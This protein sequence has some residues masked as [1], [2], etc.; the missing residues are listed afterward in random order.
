[1][2]LEGEMEFEVKFKISKERISDLLDTAF[3]GGSNYWYVIRE[4][5]YPAG[6]T[7]HD[8]KFPYLE[9]P[10]TEGGSLI[11][12]S[13]DDPDKKYSSKVL[14]LE[15]IKKGLEIMAVRFPGYF[16]DFL[17]ENEDAITG[18]VFLQCCLF[19]EVVFG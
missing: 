8:Y 19:G 13:K 15:S 11:I 10:L 5:V 16:Q 9:L 7:V 3:E 2:K 1:M 14:N 18:D 4:H 12:D 17:N 6:K